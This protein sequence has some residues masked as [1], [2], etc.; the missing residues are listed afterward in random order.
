MVTANGN[1]VTKH[2]FGVYSTTPLKG[3]WERE[4]PAKLQ[5]E[6]D[7]MPKAP[8]TETP[9]GDAMIETYTVM[10]GKNGPEFGVVIGR[11]SASGKRFVANPPSDP[12]VLADLQAKDSLKRPGK[13]VHKDGHN[14][15]L[16]A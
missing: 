14:T 5:G 4:A 15:F 6:L 3:K 2:S 11:E 8:F 10:H 9:S 12:A 16:P 1:Y 13:V 7:A